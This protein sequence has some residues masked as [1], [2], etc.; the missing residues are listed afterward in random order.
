MRLC[1]LYE[2]TG[3]SLIF[4]TF[5]H[6]DTVYSCRL[7][8]LIDQVPWSDFFDSA[9]IRAVTFC[10]HKISKHNKTPEKRYQREYPCSNNICK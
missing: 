4:H 2:L 3:D 7:L 9:S 8:G 1:I 10:Q 6:R 5:E